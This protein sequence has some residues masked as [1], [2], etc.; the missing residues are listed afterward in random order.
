LTRVAANDMIQ[1]LKR[2][3]NSRSPG[4]GD[5]IFHIKPNGERG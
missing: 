4:W 2:L 3:G 1:A 5:A